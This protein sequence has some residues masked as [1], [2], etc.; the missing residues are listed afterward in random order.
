[1]KEKKTDD[2]E[3]IIRSKNLKEKMKLIEDLGKEDSPKAL[4]QLI[5]LLSSSS[6]SIRD[7]VTEILATKGEKILDKLINLLEEGIWFT[8]A[9]AAKTL[10]NIGSIQSLPHLLKFIDDNNSVVR[11]NV[12]EAIKKIVSKYQKEDIESKL[13]KEEFERLKKINGIF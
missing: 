3:A 4:Q 2:I 5:S 7:K 1:M 9:S 11:E 13:T 12:Y 10:G 6:W 8:K